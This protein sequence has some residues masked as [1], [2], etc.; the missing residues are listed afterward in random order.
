[1]YVVTTLR[2]DRK[3][4]LQRYCTKQWNGRKIAHVANIGL[5]LFHGLWEFKNFLERIEFCRG[6][7]EITLLFALV[8]VLITFKVLSTL[9]LPHVQSFSCFVVLP[10]GPAG[11]CFALLYLCKRKKNEGLNFPREVYRYLVL[12]FRYSPSLR[13]SC[14]LLVFF[15]FC[16]IT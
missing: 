8:N 3:Q 4:T 9:L 2:C 16:W 5:I 11:Q 15:S 13:K 14:W 10:N 7:K 1:M 6:P 12:V